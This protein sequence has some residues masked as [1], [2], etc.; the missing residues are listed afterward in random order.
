LEAAKTV[1]A[2]VGNGWASDAGGRFTYMTPAVMTRHAVTLADLNGTQADRLIGWR[3]IVHPADY[4]HAAAEWR[5]CLASG[6]PFEVEHRLLRDC[7]DYYWTR[8]SGHPLLDASGGVMGWYGAFIDSD[9]P[10][11]RSQN[12]GS[13]SERREIHDASA[14]GLASADDPTLS[15]HAKAR[16]FWTGVPQVTRQRRLEAD[17]SSR[18]TEARAE[19]GYSVSIDAGE[20]VTE[21]RSTDETATSILGLTGADPLQ[22]ASIIESLFGDGWAFDAK[23]RWIYLHPFAQSSLGLNLESLNSPLESG[24]TA[25]KM[26]LHPDDYDRASIAWLHSLATG[27]DFNTEFRFR[28]KNGVYAWARTSARATRSGD[29]KITGWYGVALDIDVYKKTVSALLDRECELSQLV[30]MVPGHLWMLASDGAP[31]YFNERMREFFGFED[32]EIEGGGDGILDSIFQAAHPSDEQHFRNG[33]ARSLSNGDTFSLQHRLRRKDGVYRWLSSRAEPLRDPNGVIVNWYGLCFDIDD[34]MQAE[35]TLRRSEH[36]LRDLVDTLPV[37]I[38]SFDPSGKLITYV[39]KHHIEQVGPL[40]A[41][42]KDFDG[43]AADLTHPDDFPMMYR[44]SIAGLLAGLPFSHRFR[45]RN[46]AGTYRWIEARAQP[47][48]DEM[49]EIVRWYIISIDIED[50]VQA[51]EELRIAQ[52]NLAR[53]SQAA[54]LSELSASI[55]HEVNQP[56][57][58]VVANSHACQRWLAASPP[59][60]ERARTTIE[61]IIRDANSAANVVARIRALFKRVPDAHKIWAI[62]EV[63]T[64]A[65]ELLAEEAQQH[66]VRMVIDLALGLPLVA[67]DFVQIQQVLVNLIR[68]GIEAMDSTDPDLRTLTL[69]AFHRD[70]VVQIEVRD[71]GPGV[72]DPDRIFEPFHSS[73]RNGMGMGLAI[74]RSVIEAHGGRLRTEPN[75]KHGAAFIFTLPSRLI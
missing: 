71:N 20:V 59:N 30:D 7:G 56:L 43:M 65:R 73:K 74:C 46:K 67:L 37:D 3:Q 12:S 5:R 70:D 26:L 29:G 45:R 28:R 52:Q 66:D 15:A 50:E 51:R 47:L 27:Q 75:G 49:G 53:Q 62:S 14:V 10:A 36:E 38:M 22:C 63:I 64:K 33:L 57:A 35:Q 6:D 23:G 19:P 61:R 32:L 16:A 31:T 21:S 2:V 68:N 34:Q 60:F 39:S 42:I 24:H 55:A 58:A 54:S 4:P 40:R 1:E 69:R 25:W 17:G 18:W 8:N 41:Y 44:R 11:A 13:L 48:R 72:D 9:L